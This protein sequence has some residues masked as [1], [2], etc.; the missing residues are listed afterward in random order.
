VRL[1]ECG[2][3]VA[4]S[5][6]QQQSRRRTRLGPGRSRLGTSERR[7]GGLSPWLAPITAAES[8]ADWMDLAT[9]LPRGVLAFGDVWV[10]L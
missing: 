10:Q 5:E 6:L 1:R 4:G 8:P 7:G 9:W 3:R 2:S